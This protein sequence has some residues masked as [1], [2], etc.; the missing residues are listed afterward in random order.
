MYLQGGRCDLFWDSGFDQDSGDRCPRDREGLG[1]LGEAPPVHPVLEHRRPVDVECPATDIVGTDGDDRAGRGAEFV[2]TQL[3]VAGDG[4]R[5]AFIQNPEAVLFFD[6]Q[7]PDVV[8]P[9]VG[10]RRHSGFSVFHQL[11]HG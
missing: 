4:N 8:L 9:A 2:G 5:L 1:D 6:S 7:V 11:T 3:D 10:L